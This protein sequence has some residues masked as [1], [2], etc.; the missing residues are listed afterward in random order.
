MKMK[1]ISVFTVLLALAAFVQAA[2]PIGK[3]VGIQ[4]AVSA[5]GADGIERQLALNAEVFQNDTIK[6][7]TD[8]KIQLMFTDDTLFAQGAN[9]EAELTEYIFTPKKAENNAMG[10]KLGLGVFRVITGKITDLNPERF[11]VKTGR[12]TIGIRGC[13]L[14][15]KNTRN[16]DRVFIVRVPQGRRIIIDEIRDLG[17][18]GEPRAP[19]IDVEEQNILY[20]IEDGVAPER[21]T[22]LP[23]DLLELYEETAPNDMLMDDEDPDE[24]ADAELDGSGEPDGEQDADNSA[25]ESDEDQGE[26][27]AGD[28]TA[29]GDGSLPGNDTD[30]TEMPA[31][32]ETPDT[33]TDDSQWDGYDNTMDVPTIDEPVAE[34]G[35]S[36]EDT[37]SSDPFDDGALGNEPEPDSSIIENQVEED[38]GADSPTDAGTVADGSLILDPGTGDSTLPADNTAPSDN[39]TV[40][41]PIIPTPGLKIKG[42]GIGALY[43]SGSPNNLLQDIWVYKDLVG[44]MDNV[45]FD[46]KIIGIHDNF[47][48]SLTPD[49]IERLLNVPL[50]DYMPGS[51]TYMGYDEVTSAGVTIANDNLLQFWRRVDNGDFGLALS[52]GGYPSAE[53][54][55]AHLPADSVVK[56]DILF[57]EFPPLRPMGDPLTPMI[58][59]G[60]LWVNTRTGDFLVQPASSPALQGNAAWLEFFGQQMQGVGHAVSA[61][62][63]SGQGGGM[64]LAGF[65]A[66]TASAITPADSGITAHRGYAVGATFC[67]TPAGGSL[68]RAHNFYSGEGNVSAVINRD[69]LDNNA[70]V[71]IN[72]FQ[73]PAAPNPTDIHLGAADASF[74]VMGGMYEASYNN[75]PQFD[76]L[77]RGDVDSGTDWGWG[78]WNGQRT[79]DYGSGPQTEQVEGR[80]VTGRTLTAAD[81]GDIFQGASSFDMTGTGSAMGYIGNNDY[82]SRVDGMAT[83][84]ILI[85]GGSAPAM[86]DGAFSLNNA[87]GDTLVVN[88]SP[89]SQNISSGGNLSSSV[90]PSFYELQTGGFMVTAPLIEHQMDGSLVG[91]GTG[92]NPITGA[93]GSGYFR[94]MDGHFSEFTYGTDLH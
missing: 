42:G 28:N 13:E 82:R 4:G 89:L 31:A 54:P 58:E 79:V 38:S 18:A 20:V 64:C 56:Y 84:H 83:I 12:A 8:A 59:N 19:R 47:M 37:G 63:P 39:T 87:N 15:F 74:Y 86:W 78:E 32:E 25:G 92:A 33:S 70:M 41:D 36:V 61:A 68:I 17:A 23:D 55:G 45:A 26:L 9:S 35:T 14:G 11:K 7:G 66:T 88:Y 5:T 43:M 6:T 21:R 16:A 51:I 73:N 80:Y 57:T 44:T 60:T 90:T 81:Y 52:Y 46:G 93:I 10:M 29:E 76:G 34:S 77:A 71:M 40:V 67:E 30:G 53:F 72:A 24:D 62:N 65:Q 94:H 1:L 49:A 3:V 48:D 85:P 27:P 91:P 75:S 2:E 50:S 69:V 22:I